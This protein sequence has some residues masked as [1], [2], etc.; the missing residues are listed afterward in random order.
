MRILEKYIPSTCGKAQLHTV[1]WYPEN[2]PVAVIQIVHGMLEY[3]M[4]YDEM[5]KWFCQHGFVVCGADHLGHGSSLIDGHFGYFGEE[6]TTQTLVDDVHAFRR[7]MQ[8]EFPSLPYFIFGH[9]MGSFITRLYMTEYAQGL[10]GVILSGT[11]GPNPA[12]IVLKPVLRSMWKRHGGTHVNEKLAGLVSALNNEK[13]KHENTRNAWLSSDLSVA[14]Q[15]NSNPLT[16]FS[17]SV[18]A[19]WT[20]MD[21][22]EKIS[23]KRWA[24]KVPTAL[25]VL[26]TSGAED[27]VGDFGEGVRTVYDRMMQCDP[28]DVDIQLYFDCRHELHNE[29]IKSQVFSDWLSWFEAHRA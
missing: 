15:Y 26:L 6:N 12:A 1:T 18:S 7:V 11:S 4:R 22:L 20:L 2:E 29:I 25:P 9:S 16:Q 17:F 14:E 23:D 13:F 28:E 5:A 21:M 19:L 24:G 10:A 3:T 27:P 8:E